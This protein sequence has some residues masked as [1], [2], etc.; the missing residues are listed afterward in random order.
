MRLRIVLF[1]GALVMIPGCSTSM[2][3]PPEPTPADVAE[4]WSLQVDTVWQDTGLEDDL[5]PE[6]TAGEPI[7]VGEIARVFAGCMMD[8]GWPDYFAD[9]SSASYRSLNETSSDAER[10]D[11]YSCFAMHRMANSGN[12][13]SIAQ[14]DFVYDYYQEILIPC[15]RENGYAVLHAPSRDE[16]RTG[17]GVD[18]P[19][20]QP[21]VWN[22]YYA[23]PGFSGVGSLPVAEL[24]PAE[25]PQQDF[26]V[27]R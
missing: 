8:R 18:V 9:S 12:L 3:P 23:L 14:Y 17:T 24:C 1:A 16:F 13:R 22:P 7:N 11:W 15:L 19:A 4:L 5:R 27:L 26:Y 6:V 2:S 21:F 25:P 20:F 10:L